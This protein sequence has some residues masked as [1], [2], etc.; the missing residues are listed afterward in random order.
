MHS[1]KKHNS[2]END[3]TE[4]R[5]LRKKVAI[6]VVP[7]IGGSNLLGKGDH[8]GGKSGFGADLTQ[9]MVQTHIT[10][11][12]STVREDIVNNAQAWKVMPP[13]ES[14][15]KRDKTDRG[16]HEVAS[17]VYHSFMEDCEQ[18]KQT[19]PFIPFVY[20]I[21]YNFFL[22]NWDS[23]E[24]II[25][26]TREIVKEMQ[27]Y[28]S[29]AG[30][31]YVTHSMGAL[32]VR[33]AL[34]Q[35]EQGND[36]DKKSLA[37]QCIGVIHVAA[38]NLGAAEAFYRFHRGVPKHS[39][40][41]PAAHILGSTGYNFSMTG[42]VIPS[43]CELLPIPQQES[44]VFQ[45]DPLV[46]NLKFPSLVEVAKKSLQNYQKIDENLNMLR[47]NLD[48]AKDFHSNK[49]A[50]Y[51]FSKTAVVALSG[52]DTIGKIIY[53]GSQA[54]PFEIKMIKGDGTVPLESQRANGV[55]QIPATHIKEAKGDIDHAD[56]LAAV[57]KEAVFPLIYDLMNVLWKNRFS[58]AM[59]LDTIFPHF[60]SSLAA[61]MADEPIILN[62]MKVIF[63]QPVP[64][65]PVN[66]QPKE[67]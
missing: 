55:A 62:G 19:L 57:G 60:S 5:P 27:I 42:C 17:T 58:G 10:S 31:I 16:W 25:D 13:R 12:Q 44:Q 41:D 59:S 51:F 3:G 36:P 30:Y 67:S 29:F 38:P 24:R 6:I 52:K 49:L 46:L 56:A 61:A 63:D 22:S 32:T 40:I 65:Y 43:M 14:S 37:K 64:V 21:G 4:M 45:T 53:N 50:G 8:W 9:I 66:L 28:S 33:S 34:K 15:L 1:L 47:T 2:P 20:A 26:K 7:G 54:N 11:F 48:N 18:Q 35:M 23:A 39:L